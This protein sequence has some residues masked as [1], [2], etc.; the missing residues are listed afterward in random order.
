MNAEKYFAFISYSRKDLD[1]ANEICRRMESFR[2]PSAVE[3]QY[4]PKASKF[5]REIFLD[6]SKLEFSQKSFHEEIR[7]A[8]AQSRY[9]IVL[10]SENSAV[11]HEDGRHYINDEISFFLSQ[12]GGDYGLVV[13]VLLD[14]VK[15][16]PPIIN[17][18]SMWAR[19]NPIC[20]R[21]YG[22]G[23]ID[24]AV[25]E[26]LTYLF[27][28]GNSSYL[29]RRLNS[30]RLRRFRLM[31]IGSCV[32]A[33]LFLVMAVAMLILK[34]HADTNRKIADDNAREAKLQSEKATA[35]AM[36]AE[37]QAKLA[38][39]NA[40]EA[41]RERLLATQSLDFMV[42][43]FRMSDPLSAG[44]YDVRMIDILKARIPDIARLEPW[45]LRADVGCKVGSLLHNVGLFHDATN[46]LFTTLALN[47][48]KRPQSPETAY[49]LYCAS[50]CFYKDMFDTPS[51]LAYA[52]KALDIYESMPKRDQLKIALVS[53][54]IGVFYL[55]RKE[56][57][58]KAKK[59]L[60]RAYKIRKAEL[61]DDHVDV[62]VVCC[63]L[64]HLYAKDRSFDLAEKAYSEA[65]N[66]Y[67]HNGKES[68]IGVAKVWRGLGLVYFD[69]KEYEKAIASFKRALEI[70]IK[71]AGRGS[72][73]VVNLYR[74]I[75]LAYRRLGAYPEALDALRKAL[76][77]AQALARK[78]EQAGTRNIVQELARSVRAIKALSEKKSRR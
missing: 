31:A 57:M 73:H 40:H 60:N 62:A 77:E 42:D 28:M 52:K 46:L 18:E 48:R 33:A 30:Q 36:E 64:G 74:E 39:D 29:Y 20:R 75:G 78:N 69:S 45:E 9:L 14:N 44:Q 72:R 70:Q 3:M 4:R 49:T 6:R 7:Q 5:V 61:G 43:S 21:E 19:N 54:A 63:N 37:R 68:H 76:A 8:L 10:C 59:Y 56:D 11:P 55:D 38:V 66:I 26:I 27:H 15:V 32:V 34:E 13:P 41:E 22:E 24:G 17:T 1:V 65:L 23:G 25:A 2:Y 50:W 16:M 12:H 67:R 35:N 51:A 47:Q 53:N 58:S 71:V